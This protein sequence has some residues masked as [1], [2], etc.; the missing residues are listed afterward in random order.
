MEILLI[1]QI[2]Q[3]VTCH[4]PWV[5]HGQPICSP[6]YRKQLVLLPGVNHFQ[7]IF[8]DIQLGCLLYHNIRRLDHQSLFHIFAYIYLQNMSADDYHK[9]H[10]L[11]PKSR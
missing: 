4:V 6:Y 2:G 1:Q 5:Y 3:G 7:L 8:K 10:P 9:D 11:N